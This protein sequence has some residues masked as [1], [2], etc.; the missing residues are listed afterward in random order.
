MTQV[1]SANSRSPTIDSIRIR[2]S[3][4]LVFV[5]IYALVILSSPNTVNAQ[6]SFTDNNVDSD[7]NVDNVSNI[8]SDGSTKYLDAKSLNDDYQEIRESN[9][10][11]IASIEDYVDEISDVDT[12]PESGSIT[13]FAELQAVDQTNALLTEGNKRLPWGDIIKHPSETTVNWMR[14]MAGEFDL[15]SSYQVSEIYISSGT[16]GG[17]GEVR[18]SVYQG[19][20]LADPNGANLIWDAGTVTATESMVGVKGGAAALNNN[21][22]IWICVK[23]N[24][25]SF[26]VYNNNSYNVE[27]DFQSTNGRVMMGSSHSIDETVP[28]ESFINSTG[29]SFANYWY[30]FHIVIE[31]TTS[32][33]QLDQE[34]QFTSV[35]DY[36]PQEI[37]AIKTGTFSGSE[38]INVTYWSGSNWDLI[39]SDLEQN[40]WNNFSVVL[41][42]SMFTI[43]LGGSETT[44][45]TTIDTWNIDA[46]LLVVSGIGDDE[47]VVTNDQSDVDN[48]TDIGNL[49][50]FASTQIKDGSLAN[51]VENSPNN[52]IFQRA[53]GSIGTSHVI[54]IGEPNNYRLVAVFISNETS[55]ISASGVQIDGKSAIKVAEADNPV[56]LGNHQE[57][58]ILT[59]SGL[60]ASTGSVTV[61]LIGGFSTYAVHVMVFYNVRDSIIPYDVQIDNASEAQVEIVPAPVNIPESGLLIFGAGNG[62]AGSYVNTNWDTSPTDV[63]TSDD[64]LS[65]EIEMIEAHDG[66][67]PDSA[68]LAEAYWISTISA[69]ANRQFRA[70]GTTTNNRG[71]GII[72][73]FEPATYQLDQEIQW[74][75]VPYDMYSEKLAI[76]TGD[77]SEEDISVDYWNGTNWKNLFTDLVANAWNNITVTDILDSNTFTLRFHD[78]IKILDN[79][80]S[81]WEID[82]VLLAYHS[83]NTNYRLEWEHQVTGLDDDREKFELSIYGYS[84][85]VTE[86]FGI[87]MWNTITSSWMDPL[88]IEIGTTLQWYNATITNQ[89]VIDE[90]ITWRYIGNQDQPY[91]LEQTT[92]YI[93]YAGIATYDEAPTFT[94]TPEDIVISE[95]ST[96]N[97][98]T[99]SAYDLNPNYFMIERNYFP[100]GPFGFWN[101]TDSII[102]DIDGLDKGEYIFKIILKDTHDYISEDTVTVNVIDTTDPIFVAVPEDST[103]SE[104]SSGNKLTWNVFDKWAGSYELYQNGIL[105]NDVG[106]WDNENNVTIDIDGLIKGTYNF[107]LRLKDN[108]DNFSTNTVFVTVIDT[109]TPEINL[110]QAEIAYSEGSQGNVLTWN[111]TDNHPDTFQLYQN[112]TFTGD[113]GVWS[114]IDNL[115][116]NIDALPRGV[117]NY[118]LIIKDDSSNIA[119]STVFVYVMDTTK[120]DI[121]ENSGDLVYGQG[122]IGNFIWWNASDN[123]PEGYTVHLD[124]Q[125]YTSGNWTDKEI[126]LVNVD[127]LPAGEYNFTIIVWDD[128]NN[129]YSNTII[130]TSVA[131]TSLPVISMAP[132]DTSFIEGSTGNSLNWSVH[133]EFPFIYRIY[134]NGENTVLNLWSNYI[135]IFLDIDDLELGVNNITI[136][137]Q[138]LSR[139][140]VVHTVFI[141]VQDDV[142]PII[143][144]YPNDSTYIVGSTDNILDLKSFDN[145]PSKFEVY[146]DSSFYVSGNWGNLNN[147]IIDIDGL[148]IGNYNFTI[149]VFDS[150]YNSV[151]YDV[152]IAVTYIKTE[153]HDIFPAIEIYEGYTDPIVGTWID[154]E[155]KG[156]NL[157]VVQGQLYNSSS[158]EESIRDF[159]GIIIDGALIINVNYGSLEPGNY[160]LILKFEKAS[161]QNHTLSF[162]I[163]VLAHQ[164]EININF[165]D[166]LI[167]NNNFTVEIQV[168]YLN[169]NTNNLGLSDFGSRAGAAD[170]LEL[171]VT[172][173]LEYKNGTINTYLYDLT[174]DS[175]GVTYVTLTEVQTTNLRM[176][177]GIN[178]DIQSQGAI[179][180]KT[181]K[182]TS[183]QIPPVTIPENI[184]QPKINLPAIGPVDR[185]LFFSIVAIMLIL[186]SAPILYNYLKKKETKYAVLSESLELAGA[187]IRGIRSIQQI[188]IINKG[189]LPLYVKQ[190]QSVGVDPLLLSGMSSAVSSF[191]QEIGDQQYFGIQVMENQGLSVTSHKAEFSNFVL[192]STS[193]LPMTILDQMKNAHLM[194]EK[195]FEKTMKKRIHNQLKKED[196]DDVFHQTGLKIGLIEGLTI[197]KRNQKKFEKE[198]PNNK[199]IKL[200]VSLLANT[201][202]DETSIFTLSELFDFYND[203]GYSQNQAANVILEAYN[204]GI[205]QVV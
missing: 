145:H 55:G 93:D 20:T 160:Q 59:E 105:T 19:G 173:D 94:D 47:I 8:G 51:L 139:N 189:G 95:G 193:S 33:L 49:N 197:N 129:Y 175:N 113:T 84:S 155:G 87:Q 156:I 18:L 136:V 24:D 187:E 171:S 199:D 188:L 63:D 158:E 64:D 140:N 54:D 180:G 161:Y 15:G 85:S 40:S 204:F 126:L 2:R 72:V 179:V 5:L 152:L 23:G 52:I 128:S 86:T 157:G 41:D 112:G 196:I 102:I 78:S 32:D 162:E 170:G 68:V 150:S 71:T 184:D 91:D 38:D 200:L 3:S 79:N 143:V 62:Q 148:V 10:S 127:R 60:G 46:I 14:C 174:T 66:S 185:T 96:S 74:N 203:K 30:S 34:L 43:K 57:L 186:I 117:Y 176:I 21:E 116:I 29:S 25:N 132:T 178:V 81:N 151:S 149:I 26:N 104:G 138:D 48:S 154:E 195:K 37:L 4:I 164:L 201:V 146:L 44:S 181:I 100:T 56:G 166:D 27:S 42:S 114:N 107:T 121:L 39:A 75:N 83:T 142:S 118:T 16:N 97:T 177:Q 12:Y 50:N 202:D 163:L 190:I 82:V 92:L 159:T 101:N 17:G 205:L 90:S 120:P 80:Q 194:I 36:L 70:S 77:I 53:S 108:S 76:F 45:D 111:V 13:N 58:W 106:E 122:F 192:I 65:P 73:S 28:F 9:I 6:I 153:L 69:Q 67:Y 110:D 88:E 31:D 103:Y 144:E 115:T 125:V 169:N 124:G 135:P 11:E 168:N 119:I 133:D 1:N 141:T 182:L 167:S 131:E 134:I 61:S 109:T 172:F 7:S 165:D 198:T 35:I 137:I 99:W 183:E 89:D 123:Y 147:I 98:L 191:L 22:P 130:V